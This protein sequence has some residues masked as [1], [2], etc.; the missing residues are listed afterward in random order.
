MVFGGNTGSRTPTAGTEE[1]TG[2]E[3]GGIAQ[4]ATGKQ[5]T[6]VPTVAQRWQRMSQ[7]NPSQSE[8][9]PS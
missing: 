4:G 2:M 8:G 3:Q 5:V 7:H 6:H 9:T 1:G